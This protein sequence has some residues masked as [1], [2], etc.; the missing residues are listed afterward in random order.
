MSIESDH[1]TTPDS[2]KA[3]DR[4]GE[5]SADEVIDLSDDIYARI[6]QQ[7]HQICQS[8]NTSPVMSNLQLSQPVVSH[9]EEESQQRVSPEPPFPPQSLAESGLS[10]NQLSELILKHLY[11]HGSVTGYEISR[12]LRLPFSVVD[13]GLAFLKTE[14]SLEVNSG[15]LAGR[16]SYRF[17]LTEQGRKRSREAFDEC[18]YVGPAPVS[19]GSYLQQCMQQSTRQ[20]PLTSAQIREAFSQLVI[21]ESLLSRL[22]PA[23]LSGQSVFLFGAPGNGKTVIAKAIGVLMDRCGGEIFVPYAVSVDRHIITVFDP[24]LHRSIATELPDDENSQSLI[25]DEPFDQRWRRVKRPVI[26]TG[27]ELSLEMLDLKFHSGSGYYTAPLH[28][29]SNGGVLLIDDFGRQLV[30]PRELLNRWILPLEERVDYLTLATGKKFAIPFEQLIL[31]S[32]NLSPRELG[33]AAFLRRIRHK[34]FVP[35]P[36]EEQYREIF[37]RSCQARGIRYDDWIVRQLLSSYYNTQRQP[38]SSDPRDL[39]DIAESICRFKEQRFHLS[40]DVLAEAWLECHG[41]LPKQLV[42]EED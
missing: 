34:I 29:K 15:E 21:E 8:V 17:A 18:R 24:S 35:P 2:L 9:V 37:K 6:V 4:D 30:P 10:L 11:L 13:E 41:D 14:R 38:K 7:V 12:Q 33:D 39:L 27:G 32:T 5:L 28:M 23:I 3:F 26:L 16:L 40:E 36:S 19:I 42:G 22:G 1:K 31:F 20:I 25:N